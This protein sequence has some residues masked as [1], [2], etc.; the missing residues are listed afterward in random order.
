MSAPA[1][2]L[3]AVAAVGWL[4]FLVGFAWIA[5]SA[6]KRRLTAAEAAAFVQRHGEGE[7]GRLSFQ[8]SWFR[9]RAWGFSWSDEM[10]FRELRA[11]I[12]DGRWRHSVRHQQFLLATSG[13]VTGFS[14]V[15]LLIGWA[16]GPIGLL[17]AGLLV[18]FVAAQITRGFVR[19]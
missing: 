18:A 2:A 13:F 1:F 10:S 16:V 3:A 8:R 9:G 7:A 4:T 17:V 15:V 6:P 14:G 12:R 11:G 5:F 19:A